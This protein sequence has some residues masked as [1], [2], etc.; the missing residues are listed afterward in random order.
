MNMNNI[1]LN[2]SISNKNLF[3]PIQQQPHSPLSP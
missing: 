2:K 3:I 1:K